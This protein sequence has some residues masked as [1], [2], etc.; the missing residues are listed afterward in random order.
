METTMQTTQDK[1]AFYTQVIIDYKASIESKQK[2]M[3]DIQKQIDKERHTLSDMDWKLY[4]LQEEA[5]KQ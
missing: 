3:Q 1:I 4:E 2:Q 5:R